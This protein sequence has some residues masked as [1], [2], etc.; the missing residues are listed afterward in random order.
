MNAYLS[1][2]SSSYAINKTNV[3]FETPTHYRE[4]F[5]GMDKKGQEVVRINQT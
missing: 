1:E 3:P 4:C 2:G 5:F